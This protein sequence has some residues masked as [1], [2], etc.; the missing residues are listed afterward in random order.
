MAPTL[1]RYAE[2]ATQAAGLLLSIKAETPTWE[3]LSGLLGMARHEASLLIRNAAFFTPEQLQWALESKVSMSKLSLIAKYCR[4]VS[5]REIDRQQLCWQF[6]RESSSSSADEMREYLAGY[7]D[8]LNEKANKPRREYTRISAIPD[9][10]GMRYAMLKLTDAHAALLQN[11]TEQPAKEILSRGEAYT[12]EEARTRVIMALI[13]GDSQP[14]RD[15]SNPLD[16]RYRP[17]ILIPFAEKACN[18]DGTLVTSDGVIVDIRAHANTYLAPMG[19]AAIASRLESGHIEISEPIAIEQRY[20]TQKHRL[21]Q[22]VSHLI[23]AHPDCRITANHCQMH[24]I[25][26]HAGGGKTENRNLCPLCM[27]HNKLNDDHPRQTVHGRIDID[28]DSGRIGHHRKGKPLRFNRAPAIEKGFAAVGRRILNSD[29]RDARGH[30]R[31]HCHEFFESV[32]ID[33]EQL[34]S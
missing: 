20:A 16:P 18:V 15:D 9:H 24:H 29:L 2:Y 28:V 12:L 27:R 14:Q 3:K 31:C 30:I 23:C 1:S 10:D 32:E 11:M 21:T 22:V 4:K 26:W 17:F 7:V 34:K 25:V 33:S 19:Y 8:K 5:N 6:L 13:S